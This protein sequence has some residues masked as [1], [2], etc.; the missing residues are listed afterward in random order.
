M[1]IIKIYNV[2]NNKGKK[3]LN[4]TYVSTAHLY[5]N[6]I[7]FYKSTERS[8]ILFGGGGTETE[9]LVFE[10]EKEAKIEFDSICNTLK[11]YYETKKT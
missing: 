9:E 6:R 11:S 1:S 5:N 7:K 2:L 8:F 4:L 10:T 3:M